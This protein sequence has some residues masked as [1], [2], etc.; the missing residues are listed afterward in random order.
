MPYGGLKL[1]GMGREGIRYTMD[2]MTEIKLVAFN[3]Q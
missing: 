1:S 2:E 3:L